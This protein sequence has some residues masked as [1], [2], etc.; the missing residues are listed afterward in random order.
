MK[1]P[2]HTERVPQLLVEQLALGELDPE[3]A[4]DVTARLAA[5]PG[6]EARLAALR[7]DDDAI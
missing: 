3:R 7:A 2:T 5:E 4:R 1:E 6:G